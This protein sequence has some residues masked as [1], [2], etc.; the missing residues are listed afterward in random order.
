MSARRRSAGPGAPYLLD[1][2]IWFW[3]LTGSER[4]PGSLRREVDAAGGA[5]WLSPVSVWEL[6]MLHARARINLLGG[7]RAWVKTAMGFL[8]LIEA[9]L[10]Q[11]VALCSQEV[12][13]A[14][15]DPA[16]RFLAASALV[17]DLTLMTVDERLLGATW[18]PT[19]A[20]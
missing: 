3:H 9:P 19:R 8:P 17:Y 13:L 18:L 20:A 10:T 1:T 6:G 11:E 2:H 12:E 4:L 7:L 14:H 5:L 16:D 15:R